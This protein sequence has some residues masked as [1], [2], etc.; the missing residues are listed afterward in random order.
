MLERTLCKVKPVLK[1]NLNWI[2]CRVQG[3]RKWSFLLWQ[4]LSLAQ[5][6]FHFYPLLQNLWAA[7]TVTVLDDLW[8]PPQTH[9]QPTYQGVM[10]RSPPYW[11]KRHLPWALI[12]QNYVHKGTELLFQ[13]ASVHWRMFRFVN[14]L[15]INLSGGREGRREGMQGNYHEVERIQFLCSVFVFFKTCTE[16]SVTLCHRLQSLIIFKCSCFSEHMI[17]FC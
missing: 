12:E 2:Y 6:L 14:L 8:G 16:M 10:Q 11:H 7:R 1:E 17:T 5:Q 4:L 13:I 15:T 9:T 3:E